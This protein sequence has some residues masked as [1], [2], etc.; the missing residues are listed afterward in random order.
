MIDQN[1]AILFAIRSA[2]AGLHNRLLLGG[3]ERAETLSAQ[4]DAVIQSVTEKVAVGQDWVSPSEEDFIDAQSD[5]RDEMMELWALENISADIAA[6]EQFYDR[7]GR[8]QWAAVYLIA[9]ST[10][11]FVVTA[12]LG[13][14]KKPDFA[15]SE[16]EL[17]QTP[18]DSLELPAPAPEPITTEQRSA[19]I[20]KVNNI[21]YG[22]I[23]QMHARHIPNG[24][25][26]QKAAYERF[27]ACAANQG[28]C[29]SGSDRFA[30]AST[31]EAFGD[32]IDPEDTEAAFRDAWHIPVKGMSV[33][34]ADY[35]P[36]LDGLDR[37]FVGYRLT[38]LGIGFSVFVKFYPHRRP[39]V[40]IITDD[41]DY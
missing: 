36:T 35:F 1:Q 28:Y 40:E 15:I 21:L 39:Q 32:E 38:V 5:A 19:V 23:E 12:R 13:A 6:I 18:H 7:D 34:T 11:L 22:E 20:V 31:K 4:I 14:W 9:V 3:Y 26:P 8:A 37:W 25:A 24:Y 2:V 29:Q 16:T 27:I 10:R 41:I 30:V 17:G 33:L